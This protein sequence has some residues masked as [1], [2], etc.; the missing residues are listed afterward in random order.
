MAAE[1]PKD[2]RSRTFAP[3]EEE[4]L[5]KKFQEYLSKK[6][7]NRQHPMYATSSSAVGAVPTGFKPM[8]AKMFPRGGEFTKTFTGG[9]YRDNGLAT[10]VAKS[11][12]HTKLDGVL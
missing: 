7:S 8:P 5:E 9:A 2:P 3:G 10:G 11:R 1:A 6:Y 12:V 4:E